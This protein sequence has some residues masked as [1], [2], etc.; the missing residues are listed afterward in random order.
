MDCKFRIAVRSLYVPGCTCVLEGV[1]DERVHELGWQEESRERK[2]ELF[3]D[4]ELMTPPPPPL[5]DC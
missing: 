5:I 4:H 2:H 1:E 3:L